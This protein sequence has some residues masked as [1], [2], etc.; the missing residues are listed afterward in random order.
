M[1]ELF[2]ASSR[3][4]RGYARWLV[5]LRARGGAAA[6]N[7][8]GWGVGYWSGDHPNIEK[9]E[10]PGWNSEPFLQLSENLESDLVI[11]HVRKARH[12]PVPSLDSTHPFI[13]LCCGRSWVFAHNGLV[14]GVFE[15]ALANPTCHPR[16]ETDS[17]FAFCQLLTVID[18]SY[19]NDDQHRWLHALNQ[20]AD[21]IAGLGKFNF[22]LSDGR[23]LI[24]Y[25][26]DRLHYLES[27]Q[28][29]D[30]YALVATEPLSDEPWQPFAAHELRV[31][32]DG[33]LR[34]SRAP[35][36]REFAAA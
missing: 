24:A 9:S 7:P 27:M 11:A 32:Q 22:L 33:V 1:C 5:T 3:T 29:E 35:A 36:L 28:G 10:E 15:Q 34:L 23:I 17:E 19:A 2:G 4:P 12:P 26:H 25:G 14:S 13:H 31:Y 18:Q 21:I 16:G 30:R 20:L 8:D 6:D